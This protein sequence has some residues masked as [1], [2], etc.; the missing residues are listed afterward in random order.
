MTNQ[1]TGG[2]CGRNG[3]TPVMHS[4]IVVPRDQ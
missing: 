2:R 3:R 1:R 4:N